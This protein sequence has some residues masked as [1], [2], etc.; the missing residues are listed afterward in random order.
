MESWSVGLKA[1]IDLIFTLLP[2]GYP[3]SKH[4]LN[5][6]LYQ[7]FILHHS[8]RAGGQYSSTPSLHT[9]IFLYDVCEELS[10]IFQ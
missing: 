9:T 10:Q 4:G 1:E 8:L 2:Y 3:R 7:P 5:F 6:P